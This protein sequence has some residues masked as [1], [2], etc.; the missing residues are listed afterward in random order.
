MLFAI[1]T[2]KQIV[3]AS[4]T[5]DF[6]VATLL[7]FEK[8]DGQYLSYISN[9]ISRV[10]NTG[11]LRMYTGKLAGLEMQGDDAMHKVWVD[12][13]KAP[14]E[15]IESASPVGF[16]YSLNGRHGKGNIVKPVSQTNDSMFEETLSTSFEGYFKQRF[17]GSAKL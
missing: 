11:L 16:W 17:R 9:T 7:K 5:A 10:R 13:N 1:K 3:C 15:R 4:A 8:R 6:L 12:P 14:N 2:W